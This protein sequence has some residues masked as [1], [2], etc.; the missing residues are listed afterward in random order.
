MQS[1]A[2]V[3][4]QSSKSGTVVMCKEPAPGDERIE[5]RRVACHLTDSLF[6]RML[7]RIFPDQRKN[8]RQAQPPLVGYLGTLR[9]TRPYD[10]ADISVSGFCLLTDERWEPGTEM[11][12]TLQRKSLPAGDGSDSFTVQATVVRCGEDGVGFSIVLCEDD[13]KAVYGNPLRVQWMSRVDMERF[14]KSLKEPG[15]ASISADGGRVVR[16]PESGVQDTSS[17]G[18]SHGLKAAF[19][20]G[21]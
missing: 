6:K 4:K 19:Q 12:V 13:S 18:A 9:S 7:R 10:L 20:D 17:R 14:L 16:T 15:E 11:P 21:R 2:D 3:R 1:D 8:D 5:L